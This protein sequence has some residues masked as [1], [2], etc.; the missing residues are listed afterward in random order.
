MVMQSVIIHFWPVVIKVLPC[1]I[2]TIDSNLAS[3]LSSQRRMAGGFAIQWGA[4]LEQAGEEALVPNA[5]AKAKAAARA[6]AGAAG[7][8]G[9]SQGRRHVIENFSTAYSCWRKIP[10]LDLLFCP[11]HFIA[12]ANLY[13]V[14]LL[15][16]CSTCVF[17]NRFP[18]DC[19]VQPH[20]R[21]LC[22]CSTHG[23]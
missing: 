4:L 18:C 11:T 7:D 12:F 17:I 9:S 10:V 13:W 20:H 21:L 15:C 23:M 8:G 3:T 5:K 22:L 16:T 2:A 14:P 1:S 19:L 6:A